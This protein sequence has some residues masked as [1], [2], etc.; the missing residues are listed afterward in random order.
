MARINND[1]MLKSF[2]LMND[3]YWCLKGLRASWQHGLLLK[4]LDE[5]PASSVITVGATD[6]GYEHAT[7]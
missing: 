6:A 3:R 5:L 7:M 4:N 1:Q 2:K